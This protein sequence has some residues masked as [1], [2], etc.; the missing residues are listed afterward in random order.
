MDTFTQL[1]E[2]YGYI[3]LFLAMFLESM[4]LPVFS[5]LVLGFS[6]YL[7]YRG[8]FS[9]Y[10]AILVSALG[11]LCGATCI[12]LISRTGG[13]TALLRW[14]HLVKLTPDRV[15]KIGSWVSK[16]GPKLIIPWRQVPVIR[17]KISIV[18]GLFDLPFIAFFTYSAIGI[19]TWCTILAASGKA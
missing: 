1:I 8:D 12:F 13:R 11:S 19:F 17:T 6:G 3:A 14:G 18:A 10:I 4:C 16:Y 15:D 7:V 9:I 5:E 2:D